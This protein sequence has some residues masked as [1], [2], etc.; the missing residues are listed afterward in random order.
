MHASSEALGG[1]CWWLPGENVSLQPVL[2]RV[3][4]GS[5]SMEVGCPALPDT[6]VPTAEEPT[7]AVEG[8]A[9]SAPCSDKQLQPRLQEVSW[10][11]CLFLFHQRV[12]SLSP[13][14][15]YHSYVDG[16]ECARLLKNSIGR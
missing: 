14:C 1:Q 5:G 6:A 8:M 15:K 12:L 2:R 4:C 9:A 7:Q 10:R 11:F 16:F 13:S 3:H